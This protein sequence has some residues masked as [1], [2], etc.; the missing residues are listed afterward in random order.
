MHDFTYSAEYAVFKCQYIFACN[1]T[2][3]TSLMKEF[4]PGNLAQ[5]WFRDA[6]GGLIN[7]ASNQNI[8]G[9]ALCLFT[10]SYCI[11]C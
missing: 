1:V 4:Q 7:K 8:L 6:N 9:T 2:G 11:V 3:K 5:Q 10:Y